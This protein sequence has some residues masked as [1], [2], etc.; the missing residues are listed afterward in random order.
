MSRSA[1]HID[2]PDVVRYHLTLPS[3]CAS[4]SL[5][6]TRC[7]L[8]LPALF[9]SLDISNREATEA[10]RFLLAAAGALLFFALGAADC[11]AQDIGPFRLTG[12]DGY[13]STR[14]FR[15]EFAT[16]QRGAGQSAGAQSHQSQSDLREEIFLMTHS[17]VYHPNFLTL[18]IGGGPILQYGTFSTDQDSSQSLTGLYNLTGRATFLREKPYRGSLF[19]DH[20]NPTESIS[21]G[22]ILTQ[23]TTRYGFEFS[24]LDPV[25]PV[26]LHIDATRFRSQGSGAD[27]IIDETIDRATVR[28]SRT[29]GTIGTTQAQYQGTWQKSLS[30]SPNLP[31]QATSST[32]HGLNVDSNF[33]FGANKQY[34]ILNLVALNHQAFTLNEGTLP[35]RNDARVLLDARAALSKKLQTFGAYNYTFSGQG[36]VTSALH[37]A[38]AGLNYAAT[39]NLSTALGVRGDRSQTGALSAQSYG[40]DGS[41]R[42]QRPLLFGVGY[43]SYA[44]RYDQ[45]AQQ[46]SSSRTNVLGENI[47]LK[48]TTPVSLSHPRVIPG[49]VVVSNATR[50]QSFTE[51]SDYTLTVVGLATR[52]QRLVGGNIVDS[53]ELLVDYAYD[54]GG[55]FTST[56]LDQTLSLGWNLSRY[57]NLYYR[58]FEAWPSV[59]SGAPSSPLNT[60]RSD[61]FG[62]RTDIPLKLGIAFSLGGGYERE[63]RQETIAPYRR[64]TLDV[65]AQNDAPLFDTTTIRISAH[66]TRLTYD[67]S[68]QDVDLLGYDARLSWW[69]PLGI[70][71]SAEANWEQDTAGT[72]PR[73]WL[74]AALKAQWRFRKVTLMLEGGLTR[75]SQGTL[76]R[77]RTLIQFQI[78]R[79]F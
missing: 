43:A 58:H 49:S 34:E 9:A 5:L 28:A 12:V 30:G 75:E 71:L 26:P 1:R 72:A 10:S 44:V 45:R 36:A 39:G 19:Y 59:T 76:Q 15:G 40:V 74:S 54:T 64:D 68:A 17:Y 21:P 18:D 60:V 38:T 8:F 63:Y 29:F 25:T 55:T 31:I 47:V 52:V 79:E 62:G 46:S 53:Q 51:G 24:L 77:D 13:I 65:Y 66:R 73:Q 14:Y 57:L 70:E 11:L 69:H 50:T 35:D 20:L 4:P 3:G 32:S 2:D 27:R 16:D 56:E 23:E 7:L 61:L 6:P 67:A 41:T 78:R 42:Y 37:S 33:Q 48:G 22:Q